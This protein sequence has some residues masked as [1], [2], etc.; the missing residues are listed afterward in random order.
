MKWEHEKSRGSIHR[1]EGPK[2]AAASKKVH[3]ADAG[4]GASD[5][6]NMQKHDLPT[7]H[8]ESVDAAEERHIPA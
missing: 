5:A 6:A 7:P 8:G 3:G 4:T 2:D 1:L